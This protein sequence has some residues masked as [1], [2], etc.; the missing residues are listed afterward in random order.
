MLQADELRTK[1]DSLPKVGLAAHP[2][3]LHPVVPFSGVVGA[4][5]WIKRDDLTGFAL[6]GNK[7]RKIEFLLRTRAPKAPTPSLPSA[8]DSR[9]TRERS[10]RPHRPRGCDAISCRWPRPPASCR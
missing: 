9:T 4:E 7:A 8:G 2:T 1:I 5:V 6:G 10:P 3:P